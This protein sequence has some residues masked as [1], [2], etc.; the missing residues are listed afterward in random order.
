M[1]VHEAFLGIFALGVHEE[2][3]SV[4]VPVLAS[5]GTVG[6]IVLPKDLLIFENGQMVDGGILIE[7]HRHTGAAVVVGE[8][9]AQLG[10]DVVVPEL[11]LG[12][13]HGIHH[14]RGHG[15]PVGAEDVQRLPFVGID[16]K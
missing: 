7:L 12:L 11:P 8:G 14:G 10:A 6:G 1:V 15:E 5:E 13:I 16:L 3:N 9:L 2:L 4:G